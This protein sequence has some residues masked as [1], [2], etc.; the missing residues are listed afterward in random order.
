MIEEP[1]THGKS[2]PALVRS[3]RILDALS[4]GGKP[5]GVSELARLLELPKSTVHGLCHTLVDLGLLM[6]V[7]TSQF[8]VGPH[9]LS[10]ANAFEGQSHLTQEF[11]RIADATELISKEAINLSILTGSE[12]MYVACRRGTDPLGVSFRPGVRL[13]APFTATGKAMMSTMRPDEVRRILAG[14][15]PEPWTR[16]SVG[17]LDAFMAELEATKARGYSIDD[18]QLRDAMFCYGAP[19]FNATDEHAVA[20]LAIGLLSGEVNAESTARIVNAVQALA[21]GLSHRLGG[22]RN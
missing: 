3:K 20:G 14:T 10:W 1:E 12:V 18:G 13:P 8:S 21:G 22:R 7:G 15:W 4:D 5:K 6:R 2:V 9:V 11:M 16:R 19:V 17:S